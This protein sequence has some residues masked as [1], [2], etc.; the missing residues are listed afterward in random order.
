MPM[1]R[2]LHDTQ[3]EIYNQE[4]YEDNVIFVCQKSFT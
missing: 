4:W 2:P 3:Q 1:D